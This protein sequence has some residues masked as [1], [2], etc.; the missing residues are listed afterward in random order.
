MSSLALQAPAAETLAQWH[1]LLANGDL[2][3]LPGLLHPQAVFRSP[4]AH[5]P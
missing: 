4:M 3:G 5:K 2:S 1:G